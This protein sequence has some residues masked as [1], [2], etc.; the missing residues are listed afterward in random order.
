MPPRKTARTAFVV[1]RPAT[2]AQWT[3][4]LDMLRYDQPTVTEHHHDVVVLVSPPGR[5]PTRERWASFGLHVLA[6]SDINL[7][8][9]VPSVLVNIARDKL[10]VTKVGR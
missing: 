7:D 4:L 9:I 8:G 3:G 1:R 2:D 10:P 6:S 5:H